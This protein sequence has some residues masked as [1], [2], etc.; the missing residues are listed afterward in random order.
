[1]RYQMNRMRRLAANYELRR[2]Q[3]WVAMPAL[4]ALNLFPDRHPQERFW[5]RPGFSPAMGKVFPNCWWSK[6]VSNVPGIKPSGFD[7]SRRVGTGTP[8]RKKS[9]PDT[10]H[11]GAS[12]RVK[13]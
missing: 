12:G 7:P 11:H 2:E 5:E 13:R 3:S 10:K 8:A 1:M 9:G 6:P 4:I